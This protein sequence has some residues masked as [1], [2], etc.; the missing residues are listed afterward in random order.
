MSQD[1]APAGCAV[2]R[3]AQRSLALVE[4]NAGAEVRL[5]AV[6]VA[7]LAAAAAAVGLVGAD[8][9]WLVPLG[10][11]AARGNI[12]GSIP[13]ATAPS[14]HWHNVLVGAELLFWLAWTHLDG[15]RGIVVLQAL[16]A[17]A[18][19][20]TLA[21][22]VGWRT[23][24]RAGLLVPLLALVG[25]LPVVLIARV[26]LFS[27]ALFPVLLLVLERESVE[28]SRRIWLVPPLLAVWGNLHGAVIVGF[29]LAAVYLI[30]ERSRRDPL[31]ALGILVSSAAALF[32]NPAL[33]ATPGYYRSAFANQAAAE[34][35]GLWTPLHV[36]AFDVLLT[37]VALV[38]L[39]LA[40]RGRPRGWELVALAGLV[41]AT[42]H[43]DRFG[44][45]L[46][47]VACYPAARALRERPLRARLLVPMP[48]VLAATA[49]IGIVQAPTG[50]ARASLTE[51]SARSG[52]VVLAEAPLAEAVAADGGTVWLANPIDAFTKADQRLYLAWLAGK[53]AG[54][55]A[56]THARLVLVSTG[57]AAAI[58]AKHDPRLAFVASEDHETLFVVRQN[59]L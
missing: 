23:T 50:A 48:A 38:L 28:P 32:A 57:S 4:E 13:F 36:S 22:G 46:L 6:V 35:V 54:A 53:P 40:T 39:F 34:A 26:S 12:S 43:A 25:G 15:D 33:L 8:A 51:R 2:V 1:A 17:A 41:A 18:G 19:F 55:A 14:H 31:V 16:A 52:E 30:V 45:W 7:C 49:A 47:F 29:V 5:A 11:E 10:A 56:V 44:I 27:L 9:R 3:R 37:A 59:R 21:L 20:G 58:A 42:V 24:A